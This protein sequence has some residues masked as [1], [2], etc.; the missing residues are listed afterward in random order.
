MRSLVRIAAR[1]RVTARRHARDR[2]SYVGRLTGIEP[3]TFSLGSGKPSDRSSAGALHCKSGAQSLLQTPQQWIPRADEAD[4][5][6]V[7]THNTLS[8][9]AARA[10]AALGEKDLGAAVAFLEAFVKGR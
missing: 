8:E 2:S 9:R 7:S 3:A 10:L 4:R 1:S 5:Q 6:G